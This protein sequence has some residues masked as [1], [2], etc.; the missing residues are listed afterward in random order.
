M[1]DA[2]GKYMSKVFT[3]LMKENGIEVLQ[4]I[5]HVHQQNGC[6]EGLIRMLREKAETMRLEACLPQSWWEFTLDHATHVYNKTP[7]HHLNWQTPHQTLK[8]DKPYVNHLRVFS[9]GAYIFIPAE[10]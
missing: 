6:T 8:G 9:C 7:V 4:S 2:G 3:T 5:P 1:S 10:V